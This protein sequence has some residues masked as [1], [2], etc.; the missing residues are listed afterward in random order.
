MLDRVAHLAVDKHTGAQ[1]G[2]VSQGERQFA[3]RLTARGGGSGAVG[4]IDNHRVA[5][6]GCHT[7]RHARL[8]AVV[9]AGRR[10]AQRRVAAADVGHLVVPRAVDVVAVVL[11]LKVG[12]LVAVHHKDDIAW[13]R[14][15]SAVIHPAE[16][17]AR[18]VFGGSHQFHERLFGPLAAGEV[19]A[20]VPNPDRHGR[21]RVGCLI[22]D[23]QLAVHHARSVG[24]EVLDGLTAATAG[25]ILRVGIAVL[26]VA[27]I[28]QLGG[29]HGR[30]AVEERT[31]LANLARAVEHI[32]AH[33]ALAAERRRGEGAV[34]DVNHVAGDAVAV[35]A[36]EHAGERRS[37]VDG[38]EHVTV[39][40]ALGKA[41]LEG[42]AVRR[43]AALAAI[44]AT[45]KGRHSG[46][47]FVEALQVVGQ[48]AAQRGRDVAGSALHLAKVAHT[49][50]TRQVAAIVGATAVL[51]R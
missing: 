41:A 17:V 15:F 19:G 36:V 12:R 28:G 31:V 34:G 51:Q 20:A 18:T 16:D 5:L 3:G 8:A 30:T 47:D 35:G 49:H 21:D 11:I 40:A 10:D 45:A 29:R 33:V 4:G 43:A 27:V 48:R 26:L 22:E 7:H 6:A 44:L 38:H 32:H 25:D 46:A 13:H 24:V 50:V 14:S 1:R 23:A 9:A 39:D 42:P 2:V 37:A